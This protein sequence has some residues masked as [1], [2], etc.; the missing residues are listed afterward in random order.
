MVFSIALVGSNKGIQYPFPLFIIME[1]LSRMMEADIRG[2]F[3][4]DFSVRNANNRLSL[5][6]TFFLQM[7]LLFSVM[8]VVSR[9]KS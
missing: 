6:H 1:V 2:G 5:C 9:F 4:S 8:L 7:I 3:L